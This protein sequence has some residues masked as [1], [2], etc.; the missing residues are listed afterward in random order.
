M[1]CREASFVA[2]DLETTGLNPLKDQILSIGWV[3]M[4]GLQIHLSSVQHCGVRPTLDIP[5]ASAVVHRITDDQAAQGKSLKEALALLLKDLAGKVMIAHHAAIET[6]FLDQA[7]RNAFG[8]PCL[9]PAVDTLKLAQEQ[10]QRRQEAIRR[11]G[12]RLGTLRT[13]FNLPPYRGHDALLDA[14]ACAELF[15]AQV[16]HRSDDGPWPLRD[17]LFRPGPFW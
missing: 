7:C 4:E 8:Q 17:V 2:V 3:T 9:I 12:L 16:A 15:A 1:D 14:L 13:R 6:G 10:M 11:D 5:E